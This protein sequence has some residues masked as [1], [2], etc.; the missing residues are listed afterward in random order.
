MKN[1]KA[2]IT[3]PGFELGLKNNLRYVGIPKKHLL[4]SDGIPKSLRVEHDGVERVLRMED[5]VTEEEFE[6]KFGRQPYKLC[7]LEWEQV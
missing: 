2:K 4:G 7:Y 1:Y 3:L 6:D 5:T